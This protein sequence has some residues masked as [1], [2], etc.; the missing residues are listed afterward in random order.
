LITLPRVE[1]A[2]RA[3]VGQVLSQELAQQSLMGACVLHVAK[4][5]RH[6]GKPVAKRRAR[7]RRQGSSA[8][9]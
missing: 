6:A 5:M 8:S 9:G 3:V 2:E 7:L 4:R 1:G